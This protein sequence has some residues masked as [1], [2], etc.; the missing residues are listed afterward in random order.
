MKSTG[1]CAKEKSISMDKLLFSFSLFMI[2]NII[3]TLKIIYINKI[4]II[5]LREAEVS[6]QH[7][8][9]KY[10]EKNSKCLWSLL[11]SLLLA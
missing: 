9:A 1:S 2:I 7:Y 10:Y 4:L 3:Y 6:L 5:Y 8:F 11:D